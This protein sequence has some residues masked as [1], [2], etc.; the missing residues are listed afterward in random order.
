MKEHWCSI[1]LNT[2]ILMQK[3]NVLENVRIEPFIKD[4]QDIR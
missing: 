3:I 2:I 1:F 4:E